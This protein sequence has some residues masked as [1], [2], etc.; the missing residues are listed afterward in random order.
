VNGGARTTTDQDQDKGEDKND[1]FTFN[2]AVAAIVALFVAVLAA[3][4]IAGDG[5]TR[6]VRNHPIFFGL[7][8]IGIVVVVGL[9]GVARAWK[10]KNRPIAIVELAVVAL[11]SITI[12]VAAS[13]VAER[14]QPLV[15]LSVATQDGVA[16][17]TVTA[18]ASGLES[19]SDMLVQ[20]IPLEEFP[21]TYDEAVQLCRRDSFA[22]GDGR[23]D[24]PP[25]WIWEQSGPDA[26]GV[27]EVQSSFELPAGEYGAV[28]A[29][30]ALRADRSDPDPGSYRDKLA[31]VRLLDAD[32]VPADASPSTDA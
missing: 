31:F 28:C 4:G 12:L 11:L 16:T 21:A 8:L 17:V 19:N 7:L 29:W 10:A 5:L 1:E 3:V 26:D 9:F 18:R 25:A 23:P 20:V 24:G 6:A 32:A 13:A 22:R 30:A 27:A 15:S 2:P 14:E